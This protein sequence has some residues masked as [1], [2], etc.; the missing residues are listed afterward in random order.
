MLDLG[1]STISNLYTEWKGDPYF[2]SKSAN[3][4]QRDMNS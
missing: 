1:Y 4:L 3:I 2:L